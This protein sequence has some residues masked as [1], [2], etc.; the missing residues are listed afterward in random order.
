MV[1][2]GAREQVLQPVRARMSQNLASV[3]QFRVSTSSNSPAT[4]SAAVARAS[5]RAKQPATARIAF[6]NAS[7]HTR[8]A[9][10]ASTATAS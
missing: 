7:P 4:N 1:E 6:P 8:S 9:I 10:V 5:R 2:P 3:Q